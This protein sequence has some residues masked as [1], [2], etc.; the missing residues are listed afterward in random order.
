MT[1]FAGTAATAAGPHTGGTG[2]DDVVPRLVF[3]GAE[4][5]N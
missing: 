1:I 2:T 4:T 5:L 3:K